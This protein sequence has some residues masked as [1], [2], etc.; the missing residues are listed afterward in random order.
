MALVLQKPRLLHREDCLV[1]AP[2]DCEYPKNPTRTIPVSSD[3]S[4]YARVAVSLALA[5]KMHDIMSLSGIGG[6]SSDYSK[7]MRLHEEI[8]GLRERIVR[9]WQLNAQR[10]YID[11]QQLCGDNPKQLLALKQFE[12]ILIALHKPFMKTRVFSHRAVANAVSSHLD[13]QHSLFEAVPF[14]KRKSYAS[15]FYTVDVSICVSGVA[16]EL[17]PRDAVEERRTRKINLEKS[18]RKPGPTL[19]GL[20]SRLDQ[21]TLRQ[22][23]E[24]VPGQQNRRKSQGGPS[25]LSLKGHHWQDPAISSAQNYLPETIPPYCDGG[26]SLHEPF[27][28]F[29][30]PMLPVGE[31]SIAEFEDVSLSYVNF[32]FDGYLW[33]SWSDV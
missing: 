1:S 13:I 14:L 7:V 27:R 8:C 23:D 12:V 26:Q 30:N 15:P 33:P 9:S 17:T 16:A 25:E 21:Q 2:I 4:P 18:G 3:A 32:S 11:D 29:Q 31:S 5:H 10:I 22:A 20:D 24:Q 19:L 28:D 6:P